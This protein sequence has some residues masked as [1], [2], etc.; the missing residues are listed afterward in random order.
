MR[1]YGQVIRVKKEFLE[2]YK[3]L[4]AQP[5][6]E[7]NAK[8]KECNISNYSIYYR[9]G[10]LFSYYE[11]TGND[12]E[13]DMKKMADDPKTQEWWGLCDPCQ[14]PVESAAK[15]EWWAEMNEVYHLD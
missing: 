5:W 1:R 11:Y 7:I 4:H 3:A 6:P 15:G 10:Y 2:I 13:A 14:E 9:D 12:Y 8:I